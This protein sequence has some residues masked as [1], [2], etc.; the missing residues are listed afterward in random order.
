VAGTVLYHAAKLRAN[1]GGEATFWA[2]LAGD[3]SNNDSRFNAGKTLWIVAGVND[4][5][6]AYDWDNDLAY[7]CPDRSV[8]ETVTIKVA[9]VNPGAPYGYDYDCAFLE[10]RSYAPSGSYV[11][12]YSSVDG[13]DRPLSGTMVESRNISLSNWDAPGFY[14]SEVAG[15]PGRY[16]LVIPVD[17]AQQ[18]KYIRVYN[19]DGTVY[20]EQAVTG[21]SNNGDPL[22]IGQTYLLDET[23][24]PLPV[25]LT[26]F[27]GKL[28]SSGSE[29]ALNWTTAT[30]VN[31][32]S[33]KIQRQSGEAWVNVGEVKAN[34]NSNSP[35]NYSFHDTKI[36]SAMTYN[37]RLQMVDNDG[38]SKCS[39]SVSVSTGKPSFKLAQNYPN[40]FNP[41]TK[42][43]Y[44]LP[45]AAPVSLKVYNALGQEVITLVNE[46]QPAG[47]HTVDFNGSNLPS[48]VY[49]YQL[50]A[51]TVSGLRKMILMK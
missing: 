4:M 45:D 23:A 39:Q 15:H 38:T 26:T 44:S 41:N 30:E 48:G 37:Y 22:V 2:L 17:P 19:S 50:Q 46:D 21:P 16:G 36:S 3:L 13:S 20:A 32:S 6:N 25:E 51:G 34:G 47:I 40:P 35:K 18:I 28:V 1:S 12:V 31:F 11:F 14:S 49:V 43:S 10:G 29:V 33:F 8:L 7:V 27:S 9:N 5:W 42:I 24:A